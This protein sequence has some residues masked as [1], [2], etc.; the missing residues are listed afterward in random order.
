MARVTVQ[1]HAPGDALGTYVVLSL[2]PS[3]AG[4]VRHA[5]KNMAGRKRRQAAKSDFV[6]VEGKRNAT[7][8]RADALDGIA[9]G[10]TSALDQI[11]GA[12]DGQ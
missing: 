11:N 10:I 8:A 2:T 5:C 1:R 4:F 12:S 7:I 3:E 9:V 6:P